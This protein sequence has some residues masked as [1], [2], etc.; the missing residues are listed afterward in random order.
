MFLKMITK[1]QNNNYN[2]KRTTDLITTCVSVLNYYYFI[3][4]TNQLILHTCQKNKM[5]AGPVRFFCLF[6]VL[7][8]FLSIYPSICLF[9]FQRME[10]S[11]LYNLPSVIFL[12]RIYIF[13]CLPSF[14]LPSINK[15]TNW[16][17]KCLSSSCFNF[18]T[19]LHL[20]YFYNCFLVYRFIIVNNFITF[21]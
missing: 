1:L 12:H 8:V 20:Y 14:A 13:N 11:I 9:V 5:F 15:A 2:I 19:L 21:R 18:T 4:F 6:V 10:R 17:Y 3:S 16:F 7:S